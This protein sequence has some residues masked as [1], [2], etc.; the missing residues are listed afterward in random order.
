MISFI[1]QKT[2][3]SPIKTDVSVCLYHAYRFLL[4]F[5]HHLVFARKDNIFRPN[6]QIIYYFSSK[7]APDLYHY[8]SFAFAQLRKLWEVRGS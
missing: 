6:G 8:S 5:H 7:S 1:T 3:D 2:L 4:F